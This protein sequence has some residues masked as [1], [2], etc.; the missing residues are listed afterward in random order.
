VSAG[1]QRETIFLRGGTTLRGTEPL[2]PDA[3]RFGDL[4]MLSGRAAIDP[5]T[6]ELRGEEFAAQ[7]QAVVD[8]VRAVLAK[9]GSSL[10]DVV[11]VECWLTDRAHFAAWNEIF[12][13]SFP[14]PRPARTTTIAELP[15]AGL[16]IELQITAMVS[17]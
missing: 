9:A 7:A 5:A 2:F 10:A 14:V 11:R 13:E 8:D 6:G 15:I 12:A 4:V 1:N 17:A 3:V 16:R